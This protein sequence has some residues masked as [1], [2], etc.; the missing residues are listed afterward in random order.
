MYAW[1]LVAGMIGYTLCSLAAAR[2]AFAVQRARLIEQEPLW[3]HDQDPVESFESH[4][5]SSAATGALLFGIAW[6]VTVPG[7]CVYRCATFVITARP[8]PTDH[9][10]ERRAQQLQRRIRELEQSLDLP[11]LDDR[12]DDPTARRADTTHVPSDGAQPRVTP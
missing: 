7:Y 12:P 6:P 11:S 10:R 2:A 8:R 9:E 4:D 1:C 3:H 5:R